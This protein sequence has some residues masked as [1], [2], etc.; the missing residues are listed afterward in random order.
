MARSIIQI[1]FDANVGEFLFEP[2]DGLNVE[3]IAGDMQYSQGRNHVELGEP[4]FGE[5][6]L[7]GVQYPEPWK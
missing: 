6:R 4:G 7:I 3:T 1:A 5:H 2:S